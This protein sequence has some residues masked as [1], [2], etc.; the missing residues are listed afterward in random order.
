MEENIL[1]KFGQKKKKIE[2]AKH[3]SPGRR[4]EAHSVPIVRPPKSDV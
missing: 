3:S 2:N 4:S 1:E